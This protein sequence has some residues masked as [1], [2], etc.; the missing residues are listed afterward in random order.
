MEQIMIIAMRMKEI[1]EIFNIDV[2]TLA[3]QLNVSV[4]TY[5][6]Y[7]AGEVDIPVS[8]LYAFANRFNIQLTDLLTGDRPKL[9]IYSLV[10]KDQG[11]K[12][13]RRKEYEYQSLAYKFSHKKAE[14]FLVTVEPKDDN[15]PVSFN[16]HPGQEFNYVLEGILKVIIND[17]E[18]ILNE[19]DSLFFDATYKHAMK[20]VGDKRAKF[21]AIIV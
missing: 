3:E 8:F 1:R 7:E 20:A 14:P 13:E 16:D 11:L 17:K 5:R 18:I 9:R 19:G 6:S 10:R 15:E 21:L 2:K 4:D 12:V